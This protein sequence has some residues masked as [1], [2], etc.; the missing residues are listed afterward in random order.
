MAALQ[1]HP[2]KEAL[3]RRK[4]E[5]ERMSAPPPAAAPQRAAESSDGEAPG[6][7]LKKAKTLVETEHLIRDARPYMCV[8][9]SC[10][11]KFQPYAT[12]EEWVAHIDEHYSTRAPKRSAERLRC[13]ICGF[14]YPG[15]DMGIG[16]IATHLSRHLELIAA[17]VI[18]PGVTLTGPDEGGGGASTPEREPGRSGRMDVN[19]NVLDESSEA[20]RDKGDSSTSF[21]PGHAQF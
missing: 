1:A 12:R 16:K 20:G 15:A 10:P 21:N 9:L 3:E 5:K 2:E 11:R 19:V 17:V 13:P 8:E 4:R 18:I 14:V 7:A 6:P